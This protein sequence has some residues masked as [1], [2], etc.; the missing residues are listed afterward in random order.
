MK[1]DINILL[2]DIDNLKDLC[3][4]KYQAIVDEKKNRQEL[5]Q[6]YRNL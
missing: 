5:T 4:V 6:E 2:E 1:E 3:G